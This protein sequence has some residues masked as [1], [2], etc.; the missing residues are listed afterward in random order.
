VSASPVVAATSPATVGNRLIGHDAARPGA[1][2]GAVPP[3]VAFRTLLAIDE[4]VPV[5][6]DATS[7]S[8]LA[9]PRLAAAPIA[10]KDVAGAPRSAV[11]DDDDPLDPLHRHRAA[12]RSPETLSS[13]PVVV[14]PSL[15]VGAA[16]P[17][18]FVPAT[19]RAAASVEELI[20]LLVRRASWAGDARRGT[21]RL[22]IGAGELAGAVLVVHADAGRVRVRLDVPPGIDASGWQTRIRARLSS[23]SIE[24][25]EV[26]VA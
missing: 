13:S 16:P 6:T 22:E 12:L 3:R 7:G 1:A 19:R 2:S 17:P 11:T 15:P 9:A 8:P 4:R 18:P 10:G 20:P 21:A 14:P 26:E 24:A 23:R 25:D 5:R